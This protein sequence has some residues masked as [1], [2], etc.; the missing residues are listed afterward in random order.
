MSV[1]LC[2]V[3]YKLICNNQIMALRVSS[4]IIVQIT[5]WQE[6]AMAHVVNALEWI[7]SLI[8][9]CWANTFAAG[10]NA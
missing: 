1:D 10:F 4:P 9:H 3:F 6:K 7:R 8:K 2:S 5:H